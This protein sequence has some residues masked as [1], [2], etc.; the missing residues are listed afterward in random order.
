[1][2]ILYR[3]Q[4]VKISTTE[5]VNNLREEFGIRYGKEHYSNEYREDHDH[6]LISGIIRIQSKA[7]GM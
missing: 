2:E 4:N 7:T 3:Y 6:N 1:M 5:S